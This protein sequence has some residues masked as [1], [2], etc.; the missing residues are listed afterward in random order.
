MPQVPKDSFWRR[1]K[2]L[3]TIVGVVL[4]LVVALGAGVLFRWAQQGGPSANSPDD[5][6]QGVDGQRLPDVV[7][8]VQD[9]NSQGKTEEATKLA[10]EQINDTSTSDEVRYMLYIQQ[11]NGKYNAGDAKGAI[12]FYEKALAEKETYEITQLLGAAYAETGDKP[13]AVE[14]Y[15]KALGLVPS[16]SPTADAEKESLKKMIIAL[17]GQV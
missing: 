2:K 3:I 9:L 4:L 15:K 6:T 11:G 5:S 17:G 12:P 1:K 10:E 16:G 8:E 7:S 14:F 13:K